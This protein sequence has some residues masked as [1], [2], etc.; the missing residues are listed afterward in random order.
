MRRY[1]SR[2]ET[3]A[4]DQS[5]S[6]PANEL[7]EAV[8][9]DET[10]I[11]LLGRC[12]IGLP[13]RGDLGTSTGEKSLGH[14]AAR[15]WPA[16]E[17]ETTIRYFAAVLEMENAA[18]AT[19]LGID[20]IDTETGVV[21]SATSLPPLRLS[22]ADFAQ[23]LSAANPRQAS[24]A[25]DL[26]TE[27]LGKSHPAVAAAALRAIL[28]AIAVP[29]GFIE[30]TGRADA[31]GCM[32]QGWSEH[33]RAGPGEIFILADRL[34]LRPCLIGTYER[35]DLAARG[36][37][38][39]LLTQTASVDAAQ[40]E[41]IYYKVGETIYRLQ[42][43]EHRVVVADD[44]M[45]S[46]LRDILPKLSA[47]PTTLRE[48]QRRGGPRFAGTETVSSLTSPV[49]AAVD[50][51]F[52]LPD[53]GIALVGWMLDPQQH[54]HTVELCDDYG[55]AL[56]VDERWIRITRRDVTQ[57]YLAD[58]LFSGLL[59]PHD[60]LHGFIVSLPASAIKDAVPPLHLRLQMVDGALGYLPI[61]PSAPPSR[62][63]IKQLLSSFNIDDPAAT[64]IINEHLGPIT[65]AALSQIHTP[66]G[67]VERRFGR[68]LG[69]PKVSIILPAPLSAADIDVNLAAI[70]ADPDCRRGELIVVGLP[71]PH[72]GLS[73]TLHRYAGFYGLSGKLLLARQALDECEALEL[74]AANATAPQLLFLSARVLPKGTGWLQTLSTVLAE[75][76]S[77]ALVSPTLLYE[78]NSIKFGGTR[79]RRDGL[80]GREPDGFHGFVGYTKSWL[81]AEK[82]AAVSSCAADC[83]LIRRDDFTKIGGFA[84]E[85]FGPEMKYADLALR[86]NA[87]GRRCLWAPNAELLAF[88]VAPDDSG[89][90]WRRASAMV[91]RFGFERRWRRPAY[92]Y[93]N[94]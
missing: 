29:D 71:G 52:D 84:K 82:P 28:D 83:M 10:T 12:C 50:L 80:D 43:F 70:A 14:F 1:P 8:L 89:E 20:L 65:L 9:L 51:A 37:G 5:T 36:R 73:A 2:P 24:I 94:A 85:Y 62:G 44:V 46:H 86:L 66:A 87:A 54:L 30:V 68:P 3:D 88:D 56:A 75:D 91:D 27:Q 76:D 35:P 93:Q 64:T 60:N 21:L 79:K 59:D 6:L 61:R 69:E 16:A 45:A 31:I 13:N 18:Q 33:L 15:C 90:Y 57:G 23:R 58:Q 19:A 26:I 17:N 47:D 63:A 78:D 39:A 92:Q 34:Q 77:A 74:G 7:L 48:L 38:Y 22:V 49:R 81:D 25:C 40:I 4:P 67:F 32:I 41:A 72:D 53:T 42:L 55:F 11:L